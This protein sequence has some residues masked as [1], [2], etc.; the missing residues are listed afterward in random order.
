VTPIKKNET[1]DTPLV[2]KSSLGTGG[3]I[4]IVFGILG[5]VSALAIGIYF[6]KKKKRQVKSF[7]KKTE[8]TT[9]ESTPFNMEPP[10][11]TGG[12]KTF[13]ER[14]RI[15]N[16]LNLVKFYKDRKEMRNAEKYT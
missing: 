3:I 8:L 16:A 4:G 2:A 9:P 11:E 14:L 5:L 1:L 10:T 7:T 6:Y 12:M 15:L 13:K